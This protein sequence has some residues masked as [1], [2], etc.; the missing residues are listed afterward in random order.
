MIYGDGSVDHGI[1]VSL[2]LLLVAL[3]LLYALRRR[4]P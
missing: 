2:A 3:V 1:I 4:R